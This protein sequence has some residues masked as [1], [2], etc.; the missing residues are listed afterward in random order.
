MHFHKMNKGFTNL[1]L[2]L[3]VPTTIK[4]RFDKSERGRFPDRRGPV[5][6]KGEKSGEIPFND[7]LQIEL[8]VKNV[9]MGLRLY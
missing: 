3:R 6:S 5:W 8:S 2:C 4:C 1:K 7:F 9:K